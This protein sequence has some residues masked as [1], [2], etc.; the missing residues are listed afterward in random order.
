MLKFT[1]TF[2]LVEFSFLDTLAGGHHITHYYKT[3]SITQY[4]SR[5]ISIDVKMQKSRLLGS[6]MLLTNKHNLY[7]L[8]SIKSLHIR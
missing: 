5:L 8:L 3:S 7:I 1:E 2:N 6:I 4:N